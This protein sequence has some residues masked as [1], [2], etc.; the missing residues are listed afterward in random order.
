MGCY[1]GAKLARAGD[2]VHFL[3]RGDTAEVRNRGIQIRGRQSFE[4]ERPKLYS[5]TQEVGACD[6]VVISVKAT[7]N[8]DLPKLITPLLHAETM[9]LTLQNGFG[10]EEFLAK[11]FGAE[12]VLGALCYVCISRV[13]PG[14]VE[15]FDAGR[16][17][18]G[19]YLGPPQSRTRRVAEHFRRGGV[20]CRVV[21][22][23]TLE[24]WRKLIWNIPFNGLS[25]TSGG[26]DTAALLSNEQLRANCI[27]LMEEV[28]G[29]AEK[30]GFQLPNDI[31]QRELERTKGMG[32]YKPSTLIDF[33][34]GKRF[35]VEAIWGEP[36]RRAM[37]VGAKT[38]RL[39][40]LYAQLKEIDM[41]RSQMAG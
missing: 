17:E 14:V 35:E 16:V 2:D 19:E 32:P 40:S 18:I 10:N 36:L 22:N 39:E 26:F 37:V 4:I 28:I 13:A 33:E 21:E 38:P 5:S 11:H 15:E 12:R 30:S 6:L 29:A 23:L 41:A 20:T 8:G 9:L 27:A 1:Y 34:E 3:M 24:R 31:I 7:S 25:I